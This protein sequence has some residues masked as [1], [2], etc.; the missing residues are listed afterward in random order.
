MKIIVDVMPKKPCHCLF[1]KKS[2]S[3]IG[4]RQYEYE[5]SIDHTTCFVGDSGNCM[6]LKEEHHEDRE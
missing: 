4:N 3:Y 1:A 2:R 6:Y 5:C